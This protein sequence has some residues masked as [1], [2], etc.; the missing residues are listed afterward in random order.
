MYFS[1]LWLHS[2]F[3]KKNFGTMSPLVSKSFCLTQKTHLSRLIWFVSYAQIKTLNAFKIAKE[4]QIHRKIV[5][6][7]AILRNYVGRLKTMHNLQFISDNYSKKRIKYGSDAKRLNSCIAADALSCIV[8][9]VFCF[10]V[11]QRNSSIIIVLVCLKC[12]LNDKL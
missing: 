12:N 4:R 11:F 3:L 2:H 6:K 10:F 1:N 9:F 7:V 5:E 8:E